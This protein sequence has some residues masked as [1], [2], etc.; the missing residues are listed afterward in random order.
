MV[1]SFLSRRALADHYLL[2]QFRMFPSSVANC[3]SSETS[4]FLRSEKTFQ[5][6]Y[7]VQYICEFIKNY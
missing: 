1:P 3:V 5:F 7:R 6:F 2:Q 4:T